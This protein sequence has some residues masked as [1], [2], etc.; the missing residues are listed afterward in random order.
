MISARSVLLIVLMAIPAAGCDDSDASTGHDPVGTPTGVAHVTVTNGGSRPIFVLEECCYPAFLRL[1]A[2]D[3]WA[4]GGKFC[5]TAGEHNDPNA[6]V[7][8]I[9]PGQSLTRE[10]YGIFYETTGSGS[11]QCTRSRYAA[12]DA[13]AG[14]VCA[15]IE[16]PG[17]AY[18]TSAER[19][20]V[21]VSVQL[22]A[23]GE[24]TTIVPIA[25]D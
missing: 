3:I 25:V 6:R 19:R 13:Y 4:H 7:Q 22:P 12:A 2:G 20:C 24:A 21:P 5:G 17:S 15:F 14:T 1:S 10:W 23:R 11:E 18:S 9:D 8:R 16:D